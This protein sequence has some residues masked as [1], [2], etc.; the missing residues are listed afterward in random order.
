[1]AVGARP[2]SHAHPQAASRALASEPSAVEQTA[3]QPRVTPGKKGQS[4]APGSRYTLKN[5]RVRS[6]LLLLIGVPTLAALLLGGFGVYSSVSS[7]RAYGGVQRLTNLAN[8]VT[9]LVQ[10]L[11]NERLDTVNFITLGTNGGRAQAQSSSP[12]GAGTG[13]QLIN[14]DYAATNRAAAQVRSLAET[15][16]GGYPTLAQQQAKDAITAIGDLTALRQASVRTKLPAATVI[17]DYGNTITQLLALENEVAAGSNDASLADNVRVLSL[18][19]SMKEE[20]AQEQ[21]ILSSALLPGANDGFTAVTPLSS[22]E[23]SVLDQQEAEQTANLAAFNLAATTAQRQLYNNALSSS[24]AAPA[25]AQVQ[26]ATS[27]LASGAINTS[28]AS[29]TIAQAAT[30]ASLTISG[31]RSVEEHLT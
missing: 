16:G 31:L 11:Q 26:Q 7:A 29:S 27:L 23:L 14:A 19:S 12:S 13:L 3:P 30:N 2:H 6:R 15:I 17:A 8:D 18:V 25:Q 28:A 5:W 24:L 10:S 4:P 22:Q 20:A 9:R 1:M 21:A